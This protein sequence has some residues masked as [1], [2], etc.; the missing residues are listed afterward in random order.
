MGK[1]LLSNDGSFPDFLLF[2]CPISLW[3]VFVS[4]CGFVKMRVLTKAF[5][6]FPDGGF[7]PGVSTCIEGMPAPHLLPASIC[8]TN[9]Q[10]ISEEG[11][12]PFLIHGAY[13]KMVDAALEK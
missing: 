13:H 1:E 11:L 3:C 2:G 5:L 4:L 8:L 12:P 6:V 10:P 9:K 7:S